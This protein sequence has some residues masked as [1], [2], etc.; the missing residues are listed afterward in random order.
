LDT[1]ADLNKKR[2]QYQKMMGSDSPEVRQKGWDGQF[3]LIR[4][5]LYRTILGRTKSIQDTDDIIQETY[6][7]IYQKFGE[8]KRYAK[9]VEAVAFV[10]ARNLCTD[11][12]RKRKKITISLD[13]DDTLTKRRE[14]K[15]ALPPDELLSYE[16]KRRDVID[17]MLHIPNERD[18]LLALL[19]YNLGLRAQIIHLYTGWPT[20]IIYKRNQIIK[21]NVKIL[22]SN[23][24][25]YLAKQN[26]WSQNLSF[27]GQNTPLCVSYLNVFPCEFSYETQRSLMKDLDLANLNQL[28]RQYI[29]MLR[30]ENIGTRDPALFL[31]FMPRKYFSEEVY[32]HGAN[33][34]YVDYLMGFD[35]VIENGT[36]KKK[37]IL[38][39][40]T[41]YSGRITK[42][43]HDENG[44]I[45]GIEN[46]FPTL[47]IRIR[48]VFTEKNLNY[49]EFPTTKEDG[50]Y[51][52]Q[53][54]PI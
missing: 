6:L 45:I 49:I 39:N 4:P 42:H 37:L 27:T 41:F 44:R 20:E 46:E 7:R 43:I 38:F 14:D 53:F 11:I 16:W 24:D 52:F 2:A 13:D 34:E 8:G 28:W 36:K 30:Y 40:G 18:R 22:Y 47:G 32:Y 5:K 15:N 10:T 33:I 48:K 21:E 29:A 50:F 3:R 19:R 12:D 35:T 51:A 23:K 1:K 25:E 54:S 26:P 31:T 17:L 9:Y